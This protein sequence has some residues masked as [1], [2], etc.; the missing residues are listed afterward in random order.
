MSIVGSNILAGASGQGG[1]Y[2]I[3]QSLRFDGSSYLSW[4]ANADGSRK[5]WT[6]S[7][8]V[9][10]SSLST[11]ADN[12]F[13]SVYENTNNRHSL[14]FL[15]SQQ[16]QFEEVGGG[17]VQERGKTPAVYRDASAWMHIVE[18]YDVD[19]GTADDRGRLYVNGQRVENLQDGVT[20]SGWAGVVGSS[21][22]PYVI[23]RRELATPGSYFNGYIAEVHL[24]NNQ[25]LDPDQFGEYDDNGVWRPIKYTGSHGTTGFYLKFDPSATNGIGHDHSG[26]GNNWTASGFDSTNST[27]STYDVMS[28][29]PTTN[30]CT[31]NP[32]DA[33]ANNGLADGNLKCGTTTAANTTSIR[34]TQAVSNGK[35]YFEV[36]K[37]TTGTINIQC[38]WAATGLAHTFDTGDTGV[39]NKAISGTTVMIAAD[40]DNNAI[41]TGVDGTWDNSATVSE[42]EAGTT[43]NATHTSVANYPLAPM[44]LDQAGSFSGEANFNFGQRAFAYTPPTGFKS[45]STKNLPA[46]TVKDGSDYFQTVTYTGTGATRDITVADNSSNAWQPDLVWIKNRDITDHHALFDPVR[47]VLN[48]ISSNRTNEE[49]A[50]ANSLTAFKTDGFELGSAN[51]TNF[52]NQ[53]YVAWNWLAG[54]GTTTNTA[55]S[56]TST[57]SA[58]PSAGFSIVS[59]TG[60]GTSGATVGF[61]LGVKPGMV[62]LKARDVATNWYVWHAGLTQPDYQIYLNLTLSQGSPAFTFLNNKAPT[63]TVF[64]LPAGGY[65]SNNSGA[66]YIAYCFAEVEGYSKFGSYTG[67]GSSDG[68]FVYCGFKPAWVM[69][70][71]TD[72]ANDWPIVDSARDT[73]NAA[74]RD[75]YA[76]D[77]VAEYSGASRPYDFLSNGFKIRENVGRANTSGGT[78]IFMALAENPFGGDGVSPATAR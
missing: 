55:G 45:L 62:I 17:S 37:I 21:V 70:K 53:A 69:I 72:S 58:N 22:Y 13:W 7:A 74:Y 12:Y 68:P 48:Y 50:L 8:W 16:L 61:G 26:N 36:Q 51:L 3:E 52:L 65:G 54:N 25:G 28:D 23:G 24:V 38:G 14:G 42:I 40:F 11:S 32:L 63:N 5:L 77:S 39:Y 49:A 15:T 66:D 27:A 76:N 20:N 33:A 9:K 6:F 60:N 71:R 31:M 47:G 30:W 34:G 56:I 29:T 2:E 59:Y 73:Y 43:T 67:N 35:W 57:V 4:T 18:V 78:Y 75:L 19:N 10:R 46:P 1:A 41:W 44:F 64:E